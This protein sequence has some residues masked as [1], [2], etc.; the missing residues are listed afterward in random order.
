MREKKWTAILGAETT[1]KP[2][3]Y[4][5]LDEV[6]EL[7]KILGTKY[8]RPVI[9]WGHINSRENGKIKSG[10][11]FEEI[12]RKIKDALGK[13]CLEGLHCHFSE[14]VFSEKGEKYH[15]PLGTNNEPPF[16]L[17]AELIKSHHYRFTMIS[18]SPLLEKD[19]IKMQKMCT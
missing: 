6:L 13:E 19:A 12:I 8:I 10:E 16:K 14:Q 4:G 18:E 15:V 17:L 5:S 7:C 1:G 11:D 9:D 2:S 3:Q